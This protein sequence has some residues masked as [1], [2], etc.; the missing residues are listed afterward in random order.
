MTDTP[1]PNGPNGDSKRDSKG[2]F[3]KGNAG[4]PGNPFAKKVGELRSALLKAITPTD[5]RAIIKKL[6]ALAKSGDTTAAKIVL[7]R[8]LGQPVPIDLIERI[9]SLETLL[10]EDSRP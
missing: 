9:E 7:E 3:A 2:R 5:V 8:A 6:V 4:G 10:R 1:T